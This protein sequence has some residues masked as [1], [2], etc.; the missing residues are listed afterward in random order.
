MSGVGGGGAERRE[1]WGAILI[2]P[3]RLLSLSL[4]PPS[5]NDGEFWG[6]I[7]IPPGAA[8]KL[9]SALKYGTPY[10]PSAATE[11]VYDEGRGGSSVATYIK[12]YVPA[13]VSAAR[14]VAAQTRASS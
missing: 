7:L 3:P 9:Y 1:F 13:L 10:T 6:A 8:T 5:Q 4:S 11:I 12:N 2:R 14:W